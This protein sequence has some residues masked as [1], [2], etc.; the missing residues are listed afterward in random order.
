MIKKTL[1]YGG[2]AIV[3]LIIVTLASALLYRKYL[4]H[5]RPSASAASIS[6]SK[7]EAKT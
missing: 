4:Q 6:G 7:C 5:L 2:I 1:K 3:C